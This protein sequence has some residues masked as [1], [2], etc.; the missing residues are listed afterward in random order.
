MNCNH[1]STFAIKSTRN[2]YRVSFDVLHEKSLWE[3]NGI[4]VLF[5]QVSHDDRLLYF[6]VGNFALPHPLFGVGSDEITILQYGLSEGCNV[7]F[8]HL[9]TSPAL[10]IQFRPVQCRA[11]FTGKSRGSLIRRQLFVSAQ[12]S[13]RYCAN[14]AVRLYISFSGVEPRRSSPF[15]QTERLP[16]DNPAQR[17]RLFNPL[18]QRVYTDSKRAVDQ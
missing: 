9:T 6:S 4:A 8:C 5:D 14:V 12:S 13:P 11:N 7:E 1:V 16:D 15:A 18:G 3:R 17:W 10:V 2:V